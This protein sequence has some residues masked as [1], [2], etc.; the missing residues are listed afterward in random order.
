MDYRHSPDS[1]VLPLVDQLHQ[2]DDRAESLS[3]EETHAVF[4]L[5]DALSHGN[6]QEK[7]L[8]PVRAL[9]DADMVR[10][11]RLMRLFNQ[12]YQP[13]TDADAE[14]AVHRMESLTIAMQMERERRRTGARLGEVITDTRQQSLSLVPNAFNQAGGLYK[15]R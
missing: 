7:I 6:A 4:E 1:V 5:F 2:F 8:S 3:P 11:E 10:V 15:R 14:E 12:C 9:T 13:E